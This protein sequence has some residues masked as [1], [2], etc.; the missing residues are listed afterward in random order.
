M[1]SSKRIPAA[2]IL[3]TSLAP[4]ALYAADRPKV[5]AITGFITIDAKSYASQI[6][7]AVKFL[8]QVRD[9][10]KTAGY[11]VAGIRIST[12]PF[13]EYTRGLSHNDALSVLRGF[14]DL[15]ARLRFAPNIGPAMLRDSDSTEAVDLVTELFAAPGNHL[16]ANIVTASDDGIHWNVV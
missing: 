9:V 8:S 2:V 5:R 13:P 1:A 11:E 7:D 14:D 3:L 10:I 12:Q 4:S 16:N 6:E 15:S